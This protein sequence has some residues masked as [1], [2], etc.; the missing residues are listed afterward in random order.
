MG[1]EEGEKR[2]NFIYIYKYTRQAEKSPKTDEVNSVDVVETP[3]SR[4]KRS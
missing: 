1:G 3:D 4:D 2:E